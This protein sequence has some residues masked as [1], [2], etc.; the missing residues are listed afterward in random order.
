MSYSSQ[1]CILL[2]LQTQRFG[3]EESTPE[4]EAFPE[5]IVSSTLQHSG[6]QTHDIFTI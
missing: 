6:H 5:K 4:H 2:V 1:V 3:M